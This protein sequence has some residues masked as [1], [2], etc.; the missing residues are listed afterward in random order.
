MSRSMQTIVP[1]G[2][3]EC[4]NGETCYLLLPIATLHRYMMFRIGFSTVILKSMDL[5][6]K[7]TFTSMYSV[8]FKDCVLRSC[9]D[10]SALGW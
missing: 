7:K 2:Q 4:P 5:S 3:P 10:A 6:G 1:D 9:G 8:Q